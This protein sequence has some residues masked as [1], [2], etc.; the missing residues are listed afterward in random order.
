[1]LA[2]FRLYKSLFRYRFL[3]QMVEVRK[4][5]YTTIVELSK[6]PV[7]KPIQIQAFWLIFNLTEQRIRFQ[8][9]ILKLTKRL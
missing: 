5:F 3:L 7:L 8:C 4:R 1:M 2:T 9:P 6:Q